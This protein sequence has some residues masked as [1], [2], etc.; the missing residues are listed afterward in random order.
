MLLPGNIS[1][2][3]GLTPDEVTRLFSCL[4][5]RERRFRKGDTVIARGSRVDSFG[6]VLSGC[7]QIMRD[8]EDGT[9]VIVASLERGAIFAEAFACAGVESC[10]VQ[11]SAVEDSAAIFIPFAKLMQT[12]STSCSFHSRVIVN[13]LRM[14]ARKN[15]S[16]SGKIDVLS[17][18]T[19][20][21][22]LVAYLT[23]TLGAAR[24]KA[25]SVPFLRHELA[26]Y[27]CVDRSALSR[28]MGKMK[29]EG[30]MDIEGNSFTIHF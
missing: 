20:R 1:L 11:V 26:D 25:V 28:E 15:L 24:G 19:I 2:F 23:G 5:V 13:V 12:C 30:L 27:L 8:G 10:P 17:Q 4:S 29:D 3:E 18:R 14:F 6:I 9:R 7:L 21:G 16:L 22:K